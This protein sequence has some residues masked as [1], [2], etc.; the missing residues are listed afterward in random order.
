MTMTMTQL[1]L[2]KVIKWQSCHGRYPNYSGTENRI[3][4][5][6]DAFFMVNGE[7]AG[8]VSYIFTSRP[9][10]CVSCYGSNKYGIETEAENGSVSVTVNGSHATETDLEAVEGGSEI[11]FAARADRGYVFDHW[12][13][14]R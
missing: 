2:R 1:L 8:K 9:Y 5:A 10:H 3:P 4:A 13:D 11:V 7:L 6:E 12:N 14:M